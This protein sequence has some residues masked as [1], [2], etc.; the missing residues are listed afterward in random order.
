MTGF[1]SKAHVIGVY[2][3]REQ[4]EL[5]QGPFVAQHDGKYL[6][7]SRLQKNVIFIDIVKRFLEIETDVQPAGIN[8]VIDPDVLAQ[9][10]TAPAGF[11]FPS[12]KGF[13]RRCR[14]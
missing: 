12:P 4:I 13:A 14:A 6:L 8:N 3:Q 5:V 10:N 7:F 11:D 9:D 1:Q 2:F